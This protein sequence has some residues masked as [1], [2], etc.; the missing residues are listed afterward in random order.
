MLGND[1]SVGWIVLAHVGYVL[2]GGTD[3][4]SVY[5]MT[6]QTSISGQH[7]LDRVKAGFGCLGAETGTEQGRTDQ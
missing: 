5:R 1:F 6:G 3:H 4:F 7:I 2:I